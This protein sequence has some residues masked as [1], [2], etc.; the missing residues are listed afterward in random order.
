MQQSIKMLILPLAMLLAI[1]VDKSVGQEGKRPQ[2]RP[3]GWTVTAQPYRGP[4]HESIPVEVLSVTMRNEDHEFRFTNVILKNRAQKPVKAVKFI[5]IL[6]KKEEEETWIVREGLSTTW[7]RLPRQLPV[8]EK[9]EVELNP[10]VFRIQE[11]MLKGLSLS[12]DYRFEIAVDDV[13][14]A[15]GSSWKPHRRFW[16]LS[17]NPGC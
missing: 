4:G 11:M 15:D 2:V 14:Y 6:T 1:N 3:G 5:W 7:I 16:Y 12:G 8:S 13:L 9:L 10:R 17:A